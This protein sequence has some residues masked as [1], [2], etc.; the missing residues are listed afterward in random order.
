MKQRASSSLITGIAER[1]VTACCRW[2]WRWSARTASKQQIRLGICRK[3]YSSFLLFHVFPF[4][5]PL[6]THLPSFFLEQDLKTKKWKYIEI[7]GFLKVFYHFLLFFYLFLTIPKTQITQLFLCFLHKILGFLHIARYVA[8]SSTSRSPAAADDDDGWW[9]IVWCGA[10]LSINVTS[11]I[12]VA[13][14]DLTNRYRM[15]IA[16]EKL[17]KNS[18]QGPSPSSNLAFEKLLLLV[19]EMESTYI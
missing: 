18:R 8:F 5:G 13:A 2:R 3:T 17:F 9:L 12:A 1:K 11:K 6:S 16:F 7:G 14:A 15:F 10:N 19:M 4:F